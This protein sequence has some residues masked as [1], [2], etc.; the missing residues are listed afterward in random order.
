MVFKA[1]GQK[2]SYFRNDLGRKFSAGVKTLGKKM[3]D[4]RYAILGAGLGAIATGTAYKHKDDIDKVMTMRSTYSNLDN[5]YERQGYREQMQD[6][7]VP[8]IAFAGL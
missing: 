4:N 7:G 8:N 3:Y 2:L 6:L 5:V 1:L